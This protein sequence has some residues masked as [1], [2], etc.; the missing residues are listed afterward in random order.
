LGAYLL[1]IAL[2]LTSQ[3]KEEEEEEEEEEAWSYLLALV[4][5]LLRLRRRTRFFLHLALI[6]DNYSNCK[7]QL[8]RES[9]GCS[10]RGTYN[11]VEMRGMVV[12]GRRGRK[13][14]MSG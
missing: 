7:A 8:V 5:L 2:A 9:K 11:V 14:K 3:L 13:P 12:K 4:F 6:F 1:R 10:A